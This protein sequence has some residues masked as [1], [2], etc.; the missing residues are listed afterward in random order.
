MKCLDHDKISKSHFAPHISA[1]QNK[2][3]LKFPTGK[4]SQNIFFFLE[5]EKIK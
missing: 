1:S 2:P 3:S 4:R 5:I